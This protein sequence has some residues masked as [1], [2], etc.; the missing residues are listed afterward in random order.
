MGMFDFITNRFRRIEKKEAPVVMYQS[1]YQ[2]AEKKYD[3]RKIAKE[4]Y[5]ENAIVFRCVNEIAN[6]ASAVDFC[7]YQN[8]I[9]LDVHPLIDLL[10]RPNPQ[11]AGNEY[12]QA[13][14]SFLLLSGNSYAVY[15]LI[16]GMPRELHLLRPDRVKIVPSKT[17]I[18]SAF[19]YTIDGKVLNRYN[20]DTESGESEVKHFKMWNP[21]DDYYG[22]S[23]IQAASF[24]I[25][26]HN[27]A[28]KH[29]LGLL[30]NGARPSG[31]VIFKPKDESGM[32]LQLSDSQRQQLMS[33]LNM[34]FSG[35][36][37]AGRPMLLEGDFD[38]KE[39]GLSPKDMD[40]LELKNMSARDIALCFGGPSQLV[41]VPDNQ[42]Y[43][44][45]SEARLALYE[46]TI[47][48]LIKRVESDFNEWLAPRFGDDI[49]IRYDIDSIPAMAE[50]RKKTYENVVQAVREGIISRNEAR[51]RLGYEPVS[52]GDDVYIS[53]N[54]FPLG[55]PTVAPAEGDTADED[56]KEFD[57]SEEKREIDK[58]IFTTEEEARE[59]AQE[60]G[61]DG[62]HSHRTDDGLIYMPC[63]SHMDYERITGDTLETPKQDP[64]YG[65][66]KDVFES[67]AE[68]QARSKELGCSGHHTIKG[69]ERNYYMPCD[70]HGEY[71]KITN[72][73]DF[74]DIEKAESDI[75]TRPTQSMADEAEQGLKWRK[76]FNRGGTEV[77]VARARQLSNRQ[78]LSPDT[79][80]RM[81]SFF[82]RHEVDKE[83]E[84]FRSG[85]D[86]YP[87][88]G[89]I[90]WA[91]WGG[92]A[93]F[94]WSKRKVNELNK[95][96]EKQEHY[97]SNY[98]PCCDDCGDDI[99]IDFKQTVSARTKKTLENK[100]K[101]HNEKHGSKKGKRVTLRMLTAVFRRGVGAYRTNPE[102]VRRTV[103]GPDQWA[104]AR[105]NAFLFA[106]RTGRYRRGKFDRDLLPS[107]H[108]LKA[109]K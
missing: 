63:A 39:M 109:N 10:K 49:S 14:Y 52:G 101:E 36:H 44:N 105:V 55:S 106:V 58:D 83:A 46:D 81:F 29:N 54:L 22:L 75:D 16:G 102:S 8:N 56:D 38:W 4:G 68:A 86:G 26:Q 43:S 20:V 60:L 40:F 12:F 17:H 19:E 104:I 79:V 67:V 87:S 64:R 62:F 21:L 70:S 33:D 91:L 61:C 31:A 48:P 7:V 30:M 108:P 84:G 59:R 24:D 9:K 37:N 100:V 90:A 95:E 1:G 42:T 2:V 28:A 25:D 85:E 23:P 50:R 97:E 76:E 77:G 99:E 13:L 53:A 5:Q 94:S 32:S 57:Y 89:R 74:I 35:S 3:Y 45:V 69:P 98:I 93:G 92:D 72:S 107:G 88:A 73:K 65:Q 15:S 27:M 11:F 80:R 66:G 41:G 18:P 96:R 47:I 51:E 78:N 82:S 103:L 6:G 34:R 71:T